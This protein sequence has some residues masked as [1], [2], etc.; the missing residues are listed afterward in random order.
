MKLLEKIL[1]ATNFDKSTDQTVQTAVSVAKVFNSEIILLYVIP[2]VSGFPTAQRKLKDKVTEQLQGIQSEIEKNDVKVSETTILSGVPFD[3]ITRHAARQDVN[4]IILGAGEKSDDDPFRLGITAERVLRKSSKPVWVAKPEAAMQITNILCPV[5]YSDPSARALTN[6]IR[7]ARSFQAKLTVLN[8]IR[9]FTII[10]RLIEADGKDEETYVREGHSQFE[11]FLKKFDFHNVNWSREIRQGQ[12][13]QEILT[14]A[15]ENKADLLVM[16]SVGRTGLSRILM[17]SVASKIVRQMPCSVITVKSEHAVRLRL[18]E[19]I[20]D[21][22]DH[23]KQG[24]ELLEQGFARE[25]LKQFEHC[26]ARDILCGP[27]WEGMSIAH[28]RLGQH[29][30]SKECDEAVEQ[31][32]RYLWRSKPKHDAGTTLWS[33][34]RI[35]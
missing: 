31:I 3:Q 9:P 14:F 33:N 12:P 34:N 35:D 16:G 2:E 4:V 15:H 23:L 7:L 32:R 21:L 25:A 1:V 20:S 27:A 8:V 26:I 10:S 30:K 22:R 11:Q 24:Q 28:L 17:G 6:A 13:H 19:E 29:K 18:S 5:D